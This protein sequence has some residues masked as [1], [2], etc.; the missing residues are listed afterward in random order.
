MVN[1]LVTTPATISAANLLNAASYAGGGVAPGEIVTLF[2]ARYGPAAPATLQFDAAGRITS[3]LAGTQLF[4][5][6][7]A[8]PVIYAR[9]GQSSFLVPYSVSGQASSTIQYVYQGAHSNPVTVPVVATAPAL[10]SID[11][12]GKGP[13]AILDLGFQLNSSTNPAKAGDIV[14]LFGTGGG[15]TTPSG[16]DGALVGSTLPQ[17]VAAVAVQ[18]GGKD[19]VVQY[20]GGAPGLTNGLLQVNVFIPAGLGP[21]AQPVVLKVGGA[22]S[23]GA[24]TVAVR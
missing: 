24:V 13:G 7:V 6:G 2:D 16:T 19:A 22:A 15:A 5:D 12:S 4:F 20:A 1:A 3:T 18:I 14:S 23:T 21:G 9:T 10:F 8:A 11:S 17:P